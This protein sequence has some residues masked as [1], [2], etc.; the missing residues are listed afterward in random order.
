MIENNKK[1]TLLDMDRLPTREEMREFFRANDWTARKP[2]DFNEW[3]QDKIELKNYVQNI[4]NDIW[5]KEGR[6]FGQKSSP[7]CYTKDYPPEVLKKGVGDIVSGRVTE[8]IENEELCSDILT[9]YIP[10]FPTTEEEM[11]N[12]KPIDAEQVAK[13][14]KFV[15]TAMNTMLDT[16]GF[17]DTVKTSKKFDTPEDFSKIKPNYP[18]ENFER[19]YN[20][21]RSKTKVVYSSLALERAQREEEIL[22]ST[23][24]ELAESSALVNDFFKE[25]GE[26]DG[27]ILR[28]LLDGMTQKEIAD[29]L[30]YKNHSGVNK[31]IKKMCEKY[32][33]FDPDFKYWER[34]KTLE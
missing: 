26:E 8:I 10:D 24:E 2:Y 16:I 18:K 33:E 20:H 31:R 9:Y 3:E 32:I 12:L 23:P 15:H 29:K 1:K 13:V 28:M 17:E 34:N 11:E 6:N 22:K 5:D 25:I 21:S 4:F 7:V 19:K 27:K 14:N 30:G